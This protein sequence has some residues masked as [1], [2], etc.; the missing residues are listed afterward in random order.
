MIIEIYNSLYNH[1]FTLPLDR[2]PK[3]GHVKWYSRVDDGKIQLFYISK[4]I[5][6]GVSVLIVLKF[7]SFSVFYRVWKKENS[8]FK[9]ELERDRFRQA[10]PNQDMSSTKKNKLCYRIKLSFRS[11]THLKPFNCLKNPISTLNNRTRLNRSK[12]NQNR[13]NQ[14]NMREI[15]NL[16]IY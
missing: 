15:L 9:P 11:I 7:T 13:I 14:A 3:Q 8:E 4:P 10:R 6:N 1:S 12:T 5:L 2:F 16:V